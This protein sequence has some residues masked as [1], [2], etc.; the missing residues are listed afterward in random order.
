LFNK[1]TGG[2]FSWIQTFKDWDSEDERE[3]LVPDVN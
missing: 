2:P 3:G 1:I